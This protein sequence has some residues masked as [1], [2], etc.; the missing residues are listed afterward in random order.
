MSSWIL[1]PCLARLRDEFTQLAPNRDHASDGA[2]GDPA[3]QQESSDH[4]PDETGKTPYEDADNV[5]E[6]H[7][8]DVDDDLNKPGWT[9]QRCVDIIAARHR[10]GTDDRLQN[11]IYNL[12]I[13]SRSWGWSSWHTYTGPSPHTEHAHFSARYTTA[14]EA[15]VSP[16]GL[17]EEDTLT[18]SDDDLKAIARAVHNQKL[19]AT[20]VTIG[21]AIQ[22]TSSS[23][24]NAASGVTQ[25]QTTAAGILAAVGQVD[26][27][28]FAK[29]SNPQT[30]DAQVASALVSLLG[31]RKDAIVA[32]MQRT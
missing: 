30:P 28:L 15:D 5:N 27:Q 17:L 31:T 23:A 11:I 1:V 25:L 24:T 22:A 32:L 13:I 14:Q 16:W 8:I 4:N 9:M 20:D 10:A 2:I 18:I 26:D 12:R 21:Q 29:L 6:V 7:A 3:H 19:G